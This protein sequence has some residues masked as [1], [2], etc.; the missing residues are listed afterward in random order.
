MLRVT[1]ITVQKRHSNRFN[2]FLD[3][4]E[5]ISVTDDLILRFSLSRGKELDDKEVEAL[6]HAA[7]VAFTREKA[8]ELLSRRDHATGEL[9]TKLYQKGYQ[10]AAIQAAIEYLQS[11]NYLNDERFIKL[12]LKEL[13][14]RKQLG[15][16]KI[17]EKLFQRGLSSEL[18]NEYI[19]H[20]DFET[21]VENCKFH[22][23]KKFKQQNFE[24]RE[25]LAKAIRYLQGKGFSWEAINSV[26][27]RR[28]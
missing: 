21:Q 1:K 5:R 17:R 11:K 15:P 8:L 6:R 18:I 24:T 20:Y 9:R 26:T 22:M 27:Q 4:D 16:S 12:Y 28:R 13:I 25:D 10:K 2:I 19:Q 7:D 14:E 23:L 3:N